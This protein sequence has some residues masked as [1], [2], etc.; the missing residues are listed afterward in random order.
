MPALF[1]MQARAIRR[2]RAASMGPELFLLERAFQDCVDRLK[3]VQR[4]FNHALLIGAPDASWPDRLCSY[5]DR[6]EVRDPGRLFANAAAGD[7]IIE[8]QW[9]P[10]EATYDLI[11]SIGTLDAVNDLRLALQLI[12]FAMSPDA[13]F[14]G[15]LSGGD[16]LPQLRKAMRA[17]D[18]ACGA[19]APHVHPRVEASAL[20]PLIAEAGFIHPVVDVDRVS[21]AYR[22]FDRLVCD[23]RAMAG[24]NILCARP[25]FLG[26]AA[27]ASAM[28]AF[29]EA[30]DGS[31]TIETFEILHFAAWTKERLRAR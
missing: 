7:T 4:R 12:R 2:D 18:A 10:S 26:R 31:R 28:R 24:T 3:L 29:A 11:L 6:V 15:A 25:V 8:D 9:E 30:G 1:D 19:A 27:R 20:A 5:A 23:L 17:A 14:I 22:S 13:L 21:V 16:T